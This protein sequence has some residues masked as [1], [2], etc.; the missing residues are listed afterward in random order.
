MNLHNIEAFLAVAETNSFT[1]A[2][3]RLEKTQSA[4]SQAI[5]QLEEELG[6]ILIDRA[7]RHVTLTPSGEVMRR[8]ATQLLEDVKTMKSLVREQSMAKVSHLRIGMVDSFASA[9][10]PSLISSM[11]AEAVNLNIS[12][13][14]TP[15]LG[16]ALLARRLDIVFANDSFD[17][18]P[19]LIRYEL[20][21]EPFVLLLPKDA[22]WDVE[23]SDLASLARA[24]PM[25]RYHT[26]SYI[27]AQ[28]EAHCHRLN[29][30]PSRRIS[31]DTTE[32]L[33]ASVAAGVGWSIGNPL[34]V[35][36]SGRQRRLIR[37]AL[38]P[39]ETLYRRL[40]IV[41]R[42][43]EFDRLV[44][45]LARLSSEVLTDWIEGELQETFPELYPAI[46]VARFDS[47]PSSDQASA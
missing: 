42:R 35:L 14:V 29:V 39:G 30:I 31:V 2:G 45:R 18:E 4:V 3:K 38:F 25:V 34:S 40:C 46:R 12:S 5:R 32:K 15:N 28:I 44:L 13:D 10:G 7:S 8:L 6:V 11:M 22:R 41:A 19:Q 1:M 20:L 9:V 24:Y 43:G 37:V 27:G 47:E 33:M 26:Q 36:V 23:T 17:K 21:R 16:K